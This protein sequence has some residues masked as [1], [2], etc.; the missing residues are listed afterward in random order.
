MTGAH[1]KI[2]AVIGHAGAAGTERDS[3][4]RTVHPAAPEAIPV[5]VVLG[6]TEHLQIIVLFPCPAAVG[7]LTL[8]G[9]DIV[10]ILRRIESAEKRQLLRNPHGTQRLEIAAVILCDII[11]LLQIRL[12]LHQCP[13]AA[14]RQK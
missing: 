6:D 12:N 14:R 11:A 10:G 3:G 5:P 7:R 2:R 13:I 9:E 1:Q 8:S 4:I